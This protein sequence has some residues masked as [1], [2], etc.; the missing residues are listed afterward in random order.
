MVQPYPATF[1]SV[2]GIIT[3]GAIGCLVVHLPVF[4]MLL[5]PKGMK[6]YL[7]P[8]PRQAVC[9]RSAGKKPADSLNLTDESTFY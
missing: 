5:T 9:N 8:Y 6:A 3:K 7:T 1:W 4:A 2:S